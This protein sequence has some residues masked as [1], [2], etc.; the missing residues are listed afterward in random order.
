MMRMS[1]AMLLLLL[2]AAQYAAF[3]NGADETSGRV[4]E[5][6]LGTNLLLRTS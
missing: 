2:H 3:V 5:L 6:K 4:S 1:V